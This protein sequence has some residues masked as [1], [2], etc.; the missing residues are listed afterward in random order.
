MHQQLSLTTDLIVRI[1]AKEVKIGVIG[2]GYV[3]V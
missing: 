2:L 1:K 3:G